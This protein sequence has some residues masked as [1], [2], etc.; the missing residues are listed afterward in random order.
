M[1]TVVFIGS[2]AIG[3][4]LGSE[5]FPQSDEGRLYIMFKAGPDASLNRTGEL[6]R[7]IEVKL[8]K[9]PEVEF[10]LT[11]IGGEQTPAN[12]GDVFI[13]LKP[14]EER[15]RN[16][17]ELASIIRE[18][19]ADIAGLS[20][21]VS[22]NPGKGG[23]EQAVEFSV[24]GSDI[25]VVKKLA[26]QLEDIMRQAPGG[27]D[28]ENSE[29][30]ARPEVQ[31]HIDR[32]LADDLGISIASAAMAVRNLVDGFVVSRLKDKDE[33][34][35]IRVQLA[36]EYRNR[37]DDL[38]RL[39]IKSNKKINGEDFFVE[40][41]TVASLASASSPTEIRRYNRQKEV[42]IG[43]NLQEGYATSD[44]VNYVYSRMNELNVPA[45][46]K[47]SVVGTAE[48]QEESFGNIFMAMFLAIIFI[49]LLL[50]SQF[51]SFVDPFAIMLSLPL[52]VVGALITLYITQSTLNIMSMIGVVMLMG[53]VTKNA[54]L[55]IDFIKQLRRK[56][57]SRME[58]ILKAGPIRLRPI[59][60]TTFAMIF[61]ML[62]V[63]LS[64]GSGAEFKAPMARAVIG[65]LISS[66]LLT[67]IV[68]PV[69]YTILDD[70]VAF[71]LGKETIRAEL[72]P[73]D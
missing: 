29:K 45:G 12:Q 68:V 14:I 58:A 71:V 17:I 56:G 16:A 13:K 63:A 8:E 73:E 28:Y 10:M 7:K 61:G 44:V 70:M 2:L 52:A 47:I 46:Y 32:D 22:L 49:Y 50:A 60:M 40:L 65:G 26:N 31:V 55:L 34:Y 39:K 33:E 23:G 42:K 18:D 4:L 6:A 48:M 43:C 62:P 36:P 30:L 9:Y 25:S 35:D 64:L 37:L 3:G 72:Q 19:I 69:V 66:T 27:V 21:Q 20:M 57:L 53:L 5:F 15:D 38:Y 1:A 41:G 51:E 11:K 67:L 59:L 54:I 24:R